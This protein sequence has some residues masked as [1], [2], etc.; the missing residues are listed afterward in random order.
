MELFSKFEDTSNKA[1]P[2][3]LTEGQDVST[4]A[5]RTP[6]DLASCSLPKVEL[7]NSNS[8]SH[9]FDPETFRTEMAED[10][11]TSEKKYLERVEALVKALPP[12]LRA[13]YDREDEEVQRWINNIA[14]NSPVSIMGGDIP[15]DLPMHALIQKAAM[16]EALE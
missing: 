7:D 9:Q 10:T 6:S 16:F 15:Q 2:S 3:S 1:A 12:A 14:F 8:N 4:P 13:E 5:K 11:K